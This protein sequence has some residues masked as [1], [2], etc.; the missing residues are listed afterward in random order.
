[1]LLTQTNAVFGASYTDVHAR[2]PVI[3][4]TIS[5]LGAGALLAV[6]H[7]FSRRGWPLPLAIAMYFLV[8]IG[9]SIYSA[10]VQ[11]FSVAPNELNREQQQN[12]RSGNR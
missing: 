6:V 12:G 11:R 3:W 2:L 10:S 8:T 5:V 7:G 4:L 1:M 9:G